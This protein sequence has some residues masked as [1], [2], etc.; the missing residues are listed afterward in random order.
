MVNP[1]KQPLCIADI[2]VHPRELFAGDFGRGN[3][4]ARTQ[5]DRKSASVGLPQNRCFNHETYLKFAYKRP[6]LIRLTQYCRG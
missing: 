3:K 6:S 4:Q 5:I 1:R 2:D